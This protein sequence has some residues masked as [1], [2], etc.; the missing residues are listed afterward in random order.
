M[1]DLF[2]VFVEHTNSESG[3]CTNTKHTVKISFH[4]N[5]LI[6]LLILGKSSDLNYADN[7]MIIVASVSNCFILSLFFLFELFLCPL[8]SYFWS[9]FRLPLLNRI[10]SRFF[11]SIE[12]PSIFICGPLK[13]FLVHFCQF[14]DNIKNCFRAILCPF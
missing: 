9:N 8:K 10:E 13:S 6:F 7:L 14:W 3:S 11:W 12:V 5:L 1:G 2:Q 4:E